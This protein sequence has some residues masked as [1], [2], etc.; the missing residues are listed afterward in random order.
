MFS[1]DG[2]VTIKFVFD[3]N[4]ELSPRNMTLG[5]TTTLAEPSYYLDEVDGLSVAHNFAGEIRNGNNK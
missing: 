3:E 1:R 4:F 2:L 5:V